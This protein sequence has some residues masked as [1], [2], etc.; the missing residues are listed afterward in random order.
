MSQIRISTCQL[1]LAHD[2]E[3][4]YTMGKG[5]VCETCRDQLAK[6]REDFVEHVMRR[7]QAMYTIDTQDVGL[8]RSDVGRQFD[9]GFTAD[10]SVRIT[11]CIENVNPDLPEDVA[12]RRMKAIQDKYTGG[13]S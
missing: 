5:W 11:C 10:D 3:V 6:K 8:I 4:F 7:V 1:C 9:Q 12:L 13:Q 2:V